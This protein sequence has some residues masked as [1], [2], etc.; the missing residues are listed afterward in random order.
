VY[1]YDQVGAGRSSRLADVTEYTVERQVEDLDAIREVIGAGRITLVGRSWGG[2]LAA[3]YMAAH[4]DRVAKAIFVAAGAM[5]G[6]AYT[7][8]D[9]GEPWSKMDAQ[10]QA[11]YDDLTGAPRVLAQALLMSVNPNSAHALVPD[12]EADSWMH[13]VSLTGRDGTSCS[14]SPSAPPRNNPSL[15]GRDGTSCSGSPSAPPRNNPQGFYINQLT[16]TDF[17]RIPDPRPKLREVR[18]PTLVMAAQCDF[19]RWPVTREYRDVFSESTLVDIQ[20]AGHAVSNNQPA[21][22]VDL[23]RS[24]LLDQE[25]PLPAYTS[26]DAPPDRWSR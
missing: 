21:M 20:G 25:L 18:V 22:Y 26:Q 6:G 3:Q 14:G 19:V 11:R 5:W 10:Q 12:V 4:P 15:T 8:N 9:T 2:S 17:A 16:T 23:L 1:A 7:E 13:E 24:F